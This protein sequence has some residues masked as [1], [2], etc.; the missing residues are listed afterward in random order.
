LSL[1]H[2]HLLPSFFVQI[3][4]DTEYDPLQIQGYGGQALYDSAVYQL[5][6]IEQKQQHTEAIV[7]KTSQFPLVSDILQII[8]EFL[9]APYSFHGPAYRSLKSKDDVSSLK[10]DTV[11]RSTAVDAKLQLAIT[12]LEEAAMVHHHNEA[13]YTLADINFVSFMRRICRYHAR[14][15]AHLTIFPVPFL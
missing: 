15:V 11:V 2:L 5:K 3:L 14:P 6:L 10:P 7:Q 8:S 13:L 12:L 9:G 4:R 1:Y